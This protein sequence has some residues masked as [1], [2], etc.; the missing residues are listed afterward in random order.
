MTHREDGGLTM[1]KH[2]TPEEM[3]PTLR[4]AL[5]DL[6]GSSLDGVS[7]VT[8]QAVPRSKQVDPSGDGAITSRTFLQDLT[9]QER[10][11]VL[12]EVG[13]RS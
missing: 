11:E 8:F 9:V 1:F 3:T 10:E 5:E 6:F 7:Y 4:A 12:A 13:R 2:Q